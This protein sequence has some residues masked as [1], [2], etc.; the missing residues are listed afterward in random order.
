MAFDL[1]EIFEMFD[2]KGDGTGGLN[3]YRFHKFLTRVG[4]DLSIKDTKALM[5]EF[6]LIQTKV[7]VFAEFPNVL[8]TSAHFFR[9]FCEIFRTCPIW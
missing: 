9:T 5:L 4:V 2:P 8:L 3:A 6:S 7:R 1:N